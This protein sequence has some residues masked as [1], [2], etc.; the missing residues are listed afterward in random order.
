MG[1]RVRQFLDLHCDH[2]ENTGLCS[3]RN[4]GVREYVEL[5]D[6]EHKLMKLYRF[7]IR[8]ATCLYFPDLQID[9]GEKRKKRPRF[10][11]TYFRL[12]CNQNHRFYD[13]RFVLISIL[14]KL[15]VAPN[16]IYLV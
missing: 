2:P 16:N 5:F 15:G 3:I 9:D 8:A 13:Y 4:G 7:D 6:N 1:L 11:V 14:T 10:Y 12:S